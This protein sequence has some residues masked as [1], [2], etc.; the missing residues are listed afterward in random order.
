MMKLGG[1]PIFAELWLQKV[2]YRR[3]YIAI[4]WLLPIS[5]IEFGMFHCAGLKVHDR[6]E[7]VIINAENLGISSETMKPHSAFHFDST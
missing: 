1:E 3:F 7:K 5:Y 6:V 2:R 4:L